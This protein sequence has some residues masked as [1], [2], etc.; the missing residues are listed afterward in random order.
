MTRLRTALDIAR[1]LLWV[2]LA[3]GVLR[4]A[5]SAAHA[6]RSIVYMASLTLVE[7]A[8]VSIIGYRAGGRSE[9]HWL[10]VWL[11]VLLL[12][13]LAQGLYIAGIGYTAA[14]GIPTLFHEVERLNSF[15]G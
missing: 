14:T 11:A 8:G 3:V 2:A 12:F 13:G 9:A 7:L 4:F 1:P 6:P 5:L 15:L 10:D